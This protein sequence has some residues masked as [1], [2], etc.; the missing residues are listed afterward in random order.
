MWKLG[1]VKEG[2]GVLTSGRESLTATSCG[3]SA[4]GGSVVD[5]I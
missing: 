5:M 3:S 4:V 2:N 1:G